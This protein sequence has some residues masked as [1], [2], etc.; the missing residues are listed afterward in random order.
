MTRPLTLSR[1]SLLSACCS[2]AF[3]SGLA[4][5]ARPTFATEPRHALRIGT[6]V[7]E[8]QGKPATVFGITDAQGRAGLVLDRADGFYVRLTNDGGEATVIHWHGLTP[9]FGMDGNMLSQSPIAPGASQDYAFDLAHAGTNWLHSHHGLQEARLMAAPLIIRENAAE[10]R[11]EVVMLLHDFS[12]TPPEEILATLTGGEATLIG[13]G[14]EAMSSGMMRGQAGG[15]AGMDHSQMQVG[16]MAGMDHGSMSMGGMM[17]MD[18]NDIAFD[19]FLANDR[20]LTDPE[21]IPVERKGRVRLRIINAGSS[22]NFWIDLGTA[23]GTLTAVDG[24]P[25]RPIAGSSFELAMAQR[26]DIDLNLA[27]GAAL[28]VLAQREGDRTR[29]GIIL[30]PT[31]AAVAKIDPLAGQDAPPVLLALE[32]RLSAITPLRDRAV[33]RQINVDLTGNMMSY[34]WGLNG[35]TY[36]NRQPLEVTAGDRVEITLRNMTMMSHPMHLHGHHFQV[37]GLGQAQLLGAM[38]DTLLVPAMESVTI[39]FDADNPGDWPLHC[40]NLYHM[41]AGMMTTLSYV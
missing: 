16:N 40:H 34:V 39:A 10:D 15:M 8:V 6:R 38:R 24:M 31:G 9:P 37:T 4:S 35:R 36:D 18:L 1:R 14:M 33:T 17:Q 7:L 13:S 41:A 23:V 30:T 32:R 22:T 5:V 19:A 20:D 2:T 28:P 27:D 26:L 12:F 29:T 25:V 11:Q 21:I 3:A